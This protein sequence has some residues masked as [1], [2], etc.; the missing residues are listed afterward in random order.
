MRIAEALKKRIRFAPNMNK[1]RTASEIRNR[2]QK[3]QSDAKHES[4]AVQEATLRGKK[5]QGLGDSNERL[6][7]G[8]NT[9]ACEGLRVLG[10]KQKL[11]LPSW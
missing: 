11:A 4:W 9:D 2:G 10:E 3:G 8:G 5:D 6:P 7:E 1:R